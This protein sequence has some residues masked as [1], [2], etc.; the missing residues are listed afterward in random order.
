MS[1]PAAYN[2]RLDCLAARGSLDMYS[3]GSITSIIESMDRQ[4][5]Q[6]AGA[7]QFVLPLGAPP[8]PASI[9]AEDAA[10]TEAAIR[11]PLLSSQD[12]Q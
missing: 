12:E 8:E 6:P 7:M 9:M 4:Q 5:S 11:Q 10:A 3:S 2:V 1:S